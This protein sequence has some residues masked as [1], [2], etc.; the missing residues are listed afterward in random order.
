[1]NFVAA[2]AESLHYFDVVAHGVRA[3]LVYLHPNCI[4]IV[5]DS[6]QVLVNAVLV[7]VESAAKAAQHLSGFPTN[8]ELRGIC[9]NTWVM[10]CL[11]ASSLPQF[12]K[13]TFWRYPALT[14]E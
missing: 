4:P 10:L 1:M 6:S 5:A 8:Q 14:Q 7:Q 13:H 11:I 3:I 12:R 2:P 9:L